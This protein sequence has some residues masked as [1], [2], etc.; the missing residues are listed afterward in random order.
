MQ[1]LSMFQVTLKWKPH[2]ISSW[3]NTRKKIWPRCLQI[4][5]CN[6]VSEFNVVY[7][8][9]WDYPYPWR[10]LF[11]VVSEIKVQRKF[12]HLQP[13]LIIG[14]PEFNPNSY[15]S[16]FPEEDSRNF[17][18]SLNSRVCLKLVYVIKCKKGNSTLL[19]FF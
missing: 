10:I 7:F 12:D 13:L 3:A 4:F 5:L 19:T 17:L 14:V 18:S 8:Y 9:V 15:E 1:R 16:K 11:L 2:C 6:L